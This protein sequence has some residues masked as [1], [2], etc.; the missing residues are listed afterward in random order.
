MGRIETVL[1][2]ESR[3]ITDDV[4]SAN[5]RKYFVLK[6]TSAAQSA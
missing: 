3:I 6:F 4:D 5:K 1:L 2:S